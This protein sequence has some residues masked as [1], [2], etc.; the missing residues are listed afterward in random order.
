MEVRAVGDPQAFLDAAAP[1]LLADEARHNLILGLA[2]TL[3]DQPSRHPEYWLWL[4]EDGTEVVGAAARTPPY[5]IAVARLPRAE[6]ADALAAAAGPELP[7]AIGA[8][9]EIDWFADAWRA[10]TGDDVRVR[11]RQG[12]FRLERVV[13]P[14][15]PGGAMRLAGRADRDLAIDWWDAFVCE[16]HH[17]EAAA[18]GENE[19]S[20]DLRLTADGSGIA[21]W[22]DGGA[23][24]SLAAW[25]NPTPN[26][27]RIGPVYTPPGRRGR[28][29]ASALVAALSAELLAGG[30]RFCFLYTDLA[31]AT[32]NRIYERIGYERVC[33]S[34]ELSFTR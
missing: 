5:A 22:E 34:A 17:G 10:R 6:V 29:Y 3:R 18:P 4:V 12:I 19:R 15:P 7:G 9:P 25:G 28:G 30:R 8:R 24:V 20:V 33:E 16:A 14:P 26:G 23:V 13:E 31:N 2:A 21:L 27:V 11:F 32:A 1:L